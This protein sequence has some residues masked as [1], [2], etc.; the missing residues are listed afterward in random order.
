ME[1]ISRKNKRGEEKKISMGLACSGAE[2]TNTGRDH[3]SVSRQEA[4]G[5][6]DRKRSKKRREE[7][8]RPLGPRKGNKS[9]GGK[10]WA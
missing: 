2:Q 10:T 3:V 8:L 6:C 5:Q 7:R 1:T 4:K 9:D